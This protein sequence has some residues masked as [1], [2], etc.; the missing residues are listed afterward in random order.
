MNTQGRRLCFRS[1]PA[2]QSHR[3]DNVLQNPFE[4]V[5]L[6]LVRECL[7]ALPYRVKEKTRLLAACFR[8]TVIWRAGLSSNPYV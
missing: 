7:F 6:L 1:S 4:F 2:I 8:D 5:R 3:P